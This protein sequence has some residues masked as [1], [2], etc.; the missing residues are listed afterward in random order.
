MFWYRHR[1]LWTPLC[2]SAGV[3]L[4]AGLVELGDASQ[5]LSVVDVG[6]LVLSKGRLQLLQLLVAEGGAVASPGRRRVGPAP[7]AE[8]RAHGG[9]AGLPRRPRYICFQGEEWERLGFAW[10]LKRPFL[11]TILRLPFPE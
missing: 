8:A 3:D 10:T 4:Y 11:E 2:V 1:S 6:I 9:L 7:P 5:L